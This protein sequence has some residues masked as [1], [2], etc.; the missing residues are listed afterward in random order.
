MYGPEYV[1]ILNPGAGTVDDWVRIADKELQRNESSSFCSREQY[2]QAVDGTFIVDASILR[3]DVNTTTAS[4]LVR[5]N[6]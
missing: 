1:W 6:S 4:G 3:N 2:Q 5:K